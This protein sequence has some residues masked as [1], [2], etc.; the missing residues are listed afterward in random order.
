MENMSP[1]GDPGGDEYKNPLT[2]D[3]AGA[4]G[5]DSEPG[6]GGKPGDEENDDNG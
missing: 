4:G 1:R 3:S 2:K 6:S 5:D